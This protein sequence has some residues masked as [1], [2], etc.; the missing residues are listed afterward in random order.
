MIH[1]DK[2]IFIGDAKLRK[3]NGNMST[4]WKHNIAFLGHA[5][6]RKVKDPIF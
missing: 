2:V 4:K 6:H 1:I 5:I 3:H